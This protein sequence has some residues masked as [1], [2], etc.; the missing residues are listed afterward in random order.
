MSGIVDDSLVTLREVDSLRGRVRSW[1]KAGLSVA[2]V[3]TMGALHRGHVTLMERAHAMADRVV[4]TIFVNPTQFAPGEDFTAYPR[5]EAEDFEKLRAA[6]VHVLFAPSPAVMYPPGFATAVRVAGLTD[7]LC[8]PLRPGHFEGVATVVTKLLHQTGP[9]IAL[10]GE[11]DFQQLAVIRRC[12]SDLDIPI[13]II[14]VPTVREAD[15]LALSSR[16]VYLTAD[17]RARA[18]A[19]FRALTTAAHAIARGDDPRR[20]EAVAREE[21][22]NAGFR[23]IDYVE[24]RRADTL[25]LLGANTERAS[26]APERVFAAA[27]LGR[28]RLIDNVEIASPGQRT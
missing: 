2:L 19:L 9:D 1:K 7:V 4:A 26:I 3:P 21:I 14:G 15:G 16:N 11:K 6:G 22:M 28:A 20:A 25:A 8:G 23:A 13:E 27:H 12:V 18:P 5:Q 17:E 10:F 24:A